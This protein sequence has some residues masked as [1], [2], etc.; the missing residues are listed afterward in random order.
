MK[1]F[2]AIRLKSS[3]RKTAPIPNIVRAKNVSLSFLS[4]MKGP[5]QRYA[6]TPNKTTQTAKYLV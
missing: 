2:F 4:D 1:G 5:G 6:T 3:T